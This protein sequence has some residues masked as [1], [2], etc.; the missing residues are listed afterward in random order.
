MQVDRILEVLETTSELRV[1]NESFKK[2]ACQGMKSKK[3][4]S[5]GTSKS[6]SES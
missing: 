2:A 3:G 4:E 5:D 1:T 6:Q